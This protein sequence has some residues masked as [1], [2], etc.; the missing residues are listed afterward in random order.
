MTSQ[1]IQ[2]SVLGGTT[3]KVDANRSEIEELRRSVGD[4]RSA[5]DQL[6]QDVDKLSLA[7]DNVKNELKTVGKTGL[8][9]QSNVAKAATYSK[10]GVQDNVN[11]INNILRRQNNA[12]FLAIVTGVMALRL[13]TL[14][15]HTQ[16]TN[17]EN[18][19]WIASLSVLATQSLVNVLMWFYIVRHVS[20]GNFDG[21]GRGIKTVSLC[22][23]GLS[24]AHNSLSIADIVTN[25][26]PFEGDPRKGATVDLIMQIFNAT[27]NTAFVLAGAYGVRKGATV[28]SKRSTTM[29]NFAEFAMNL[30]QVS[31]SA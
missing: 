7:M 25:R 22:L 23:T 9:N 12:V 8:E 28:E 14:S 5:M 21:P 4:N 27:L 30:S 15:S 18:P 13:A 24:L 26:Q 17:W 2:R 16:K 10:D 3:R 19:L 20:K 31:S 6:R 11:A 1:V 29:R